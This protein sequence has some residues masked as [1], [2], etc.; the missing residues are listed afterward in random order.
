RQAD[1]GTGQDS[2]GVMQRCWLMRATPLSARRRLLGTVAQA[3]N[4]R[5]SRL[6]AIS[7]RSE[8]GM[9]VCVLTHRCP[10]RPIWQRQS[11]W[12]HGVNTAGPERAPYA[13]LKE[14]T[15]YLNPEAIDYHAFSKNDD[16]Y[17]YQLQHT[18]WLIANT[19]ADLL[20]IAPGNIADTVKAQWQDG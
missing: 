13:A 4:M 14:T 12:C 11:E 15:M 6:A 20:A 17:F 3:A 10:T 1:P 5:S 18:L 2:P 19:G 8:A 9:Q 16:P 7:R